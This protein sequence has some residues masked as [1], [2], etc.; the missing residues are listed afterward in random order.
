M[1]LR[2]RVIAVALAALAIIALLGAQL[3]A[4]YAQTQSSLNEVVESLGPASAAVAD[5]SEDINSMERQLRIFVSSGAEGLAVLHEASVDSA[6]GNIEQLRVLLRGRAQELALVAEVDANLDLWLANV[7]TPVTTA[8]T[9]DQQLLAQQTLDSNG[10]EAAY[11]LLA[12]DTK[13][14]SGVLGGQ[15]TRALAASS[16]SATRLAWTLAAALVVLLLLPLAAYIAVRRH[17]LGPIAALREQLRTAA[18]PEHHDSVIVPV[19]PPELRALGADAEALRRALVR[20][21]DQAMAARQALEHEGP[22]VEGI[23]RE[24]EARSEAPPLG[25]TISGMLRPAEGVLAGDFWDR[26]ALPDGRAAAVV[27]DVT[28]HGPQAGIVAMRLKTSI[29]LGLIAG[30]DPPQVLHRACDAFADEPGR[31]ATVVILIADTATGE[32]TWVNAGHPAPRI[33]RADG[34][35]E[36]LD[37]TGPMVS[38]LGG[39]WTMGSI[40]ATPN[41]VVLAFTDG[42]LESRDAE[43][44]ELGDADLDDHLRAAVAKADDPT[45]V[46]A[47]ALASVR[48][49]ATHLGRD[50]VTL[51][52]MQ[53]DEPAPAP[54]PHARG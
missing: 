38:W 3:V 12:G 39:V 1:T 8:M 40:H 10:A 43:G 32:I 11:A 19:G 35:I 47:Q 46:I 5:L 4:R 51:V 33:V 41:D 20:E 30:Q 34:S 23:R 21:I 22:V 15:Q 13:R 29:T 6:R 52:A 53:L 31:F 37:T 42:I 17:V 25:V 16:D 44:N 50:D 7:A 14:L 9:D 2:Q 54:T 45:E 24:L 18:E 49:R 27:C 28:G 48:E 36:T 26:M